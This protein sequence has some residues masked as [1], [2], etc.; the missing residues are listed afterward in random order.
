MSNVSKFRIGSR[1]FGRI[2]L[3][4][5]RWRFIGVLGIDSRCTAFVWDYGKRIDWPSTVT[6]MVYQSV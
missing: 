6:L 4:G 1:S 5:R 2:L 3:I